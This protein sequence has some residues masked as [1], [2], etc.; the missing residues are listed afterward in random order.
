MFSCRPFLS[1]GAFFR[2]ACEYMLY[3]SC[4]FNLLIKSHRSKEKR[5][6]KI[7]SGMEGFTMLS[8]MGWEWDVIILFSGPGGIVSI[9]EV[10]C[11]ALLVGM[12]E[13]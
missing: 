9:N 5:R 6:E 10:E 13:A 11:L 3:I 7:S 12:H 2:L 8:G 4:T 1:F